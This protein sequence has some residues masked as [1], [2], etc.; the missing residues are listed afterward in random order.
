MKQTND[1]ST[2]FKLN[3]DFTGIQVTNFVFDYE[4]VV[5]GERFDIQV[6]V[7]VKEQIVSITNIDCIDYELTKEE[8]EFIENDF[9]DYIKKDELNLPESIYYDCSRDNLISK[10][11]YLQ[12]F[13]GGDW[14]PHHII[15][16]E[17]LEVV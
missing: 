6:Y 10:E 12:D 16:S 5:D 7:Q 4:G 8:K 3:R 9:L 1:M 13:V 2:T 17:K 11:G 15:G 14:Y